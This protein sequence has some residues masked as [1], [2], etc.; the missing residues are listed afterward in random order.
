MSRILGKRPRDGVAPSYILY[1][2]GL[3]DE[4]L[5]EEALRDEFSQWGR[6]L[7]TRLINHTTW[8]HAFVQMASLADAARAVAAF[9]AP[10]GW[11]PYGHFSAKVNFST[12][13]AAHDARAAPSPLPP[14]V[15]APPNVASSSATTD[16]DL[17]P[18]MA[19]DYLCTIEQTMRVKE[20]SDGN[21][22][23]DAAIRKHLIQLTTREGLA[24]VLEVCPM[25]PQCR[26]S[27]LVSA[28]T[29]SVA[30]AR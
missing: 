7:S 9:R 4:L 12:N 2:C 16:A 17:L 20:G 3:K 11:R 23:A 24:H 30:G 18:S 8:S 21:F 14:S 10:G 26:A 15:T 28:R 1:V 13:P 19:E 5:A 27:Y 25:P 6:V 29:R 22:V